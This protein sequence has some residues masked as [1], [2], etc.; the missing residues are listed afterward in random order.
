MTSTYFILKTHPEVINPIQILKLDPSIYNNQVSLEMYKKTS[1]LVVGYFDSGPDVEIC[2]VLEMPVWLI[3]DQV[4]RLFHLYESSM[5]FKGV[6]V[7]SIYPEDNTS[8]LYWWPYIEP[9]ECLSEK[10]QKYENGTLKELVLKSAPVLQRHIFRVSGL[11]EHRVI[12]SLPVAESLLRRGLI[13]IG[14][15]PVKFE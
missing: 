6:Q 5:A 2:D 14:L 7:F 3:S 10:T 12:V 15:E 11:L 13:G 1:E 8:P 4:K 9:V